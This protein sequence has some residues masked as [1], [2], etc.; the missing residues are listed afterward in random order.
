MNGFLRRLQSDV[1]R[2]LMGDFQEYGVLGRRLLK[3]KQFKIEEERRRQEQEVQE[4]HELERWGKQMEARRAALAQEELRQRQEKLAI[5]FEY[6]VLFHGNEVDF[7][8]DK[9][10]VA[11][12]LRVFVE[13]QLIEN[14]RSR[15]RPFK[16]RVDG[17]AV[18]PGLSRLIRKMSLGTRC[19]AILPPEM[20]YG[21]QGLPPK[22]P[23]HATVELD[24]ELVGVELSTDMQELLSDSESDYDDQDGDEEEDP[25]DQEE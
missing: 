5:T 14:S 16:F 6:E 22:I 9:S 8:D 3:P 24:V 7:P 15:G 13:G 18:I 4:A 20:A 19:H 17:G 1:K 10:V 2:S 21:E 23:R 11:V 25:R 12:H